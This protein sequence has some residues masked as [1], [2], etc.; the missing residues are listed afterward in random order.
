MVYKGMETNVLTNICVCVCFLPSKNHGSN[1]ATTVGGGTLQR[2]FVSQ[3]AISVKG[4]NY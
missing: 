1:C 2:R 4:W 3:E